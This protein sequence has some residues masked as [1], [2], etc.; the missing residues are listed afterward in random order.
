MTRRVVV[1]NG[2]PATLVI[3]QADFLTGF[4]DFAPAPN[5]G[6][7][8]AANLWFPQG[9]AVDPIGNLFVADSSNHRV[10]EFP[11]P[12]AGCN[13]SSCVV[14]NAH[15][16]FGQTDFVSNQVNGTGVGVANQ[17]GLWIPT[18]VAL[19]ANE[20]LYVADLNNSR[21]VKYNSVLASNAQG[22]NADA[23]Y[24]QPDFVTSTCPNASSPGPS[25]FCNPQTVAVDASGNV[26]ITYPADGCVLEY[27]SGHTAQA[28][29]VLGTANFNSFVCPNNQTI[30]TATSVCYPSGL[31][32]DPAGNL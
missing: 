1:S 6:L 28:D 15:L 17:H 4:T 16:V 19:D 31:G 11:T 5:S 29:H 8:T 27:D 9:I 14:G 13:N 7:P 25:K 20:N 10:L 22:R 3:G 32:V 2:D 12:F 30:A 26:Y 23:V 18:G 21:V 24:G